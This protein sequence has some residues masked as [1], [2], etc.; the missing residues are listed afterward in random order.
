MGRVIGIDLGE[1]RIGIA[2]SDE[3]QTIS[4]AVRTLQVKGIKSCLNAV[5]DIVK[6][7]NAQAVVIGLPLNMDGTKGPKAQESMDF[8][9]RLSSKIK[10]RVLTFDERLTTSQGQRILLSA[11]M[12]RKK[13]KGNIDKLAAQIMLQTYLDSVK[14]K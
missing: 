1:K 12:S 3:T 11:D 5:A 7:Y 14:I 13:R 10:A 4:S 9:K 6:F 2:V 8:A